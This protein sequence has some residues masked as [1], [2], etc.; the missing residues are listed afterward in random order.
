MSWPKLVSA[1]VVGALVAAGALVLSGVVPL[2]AAQAA[3]V[4]AAQ[5]SCPAPVDPRAINRTTDA[6]AKIDGIQGDSTSAAHRGE[7][8]LTSVRFALLGGASGLCGSG[9][10]STFNPVIVEKRVD[11]ASVPLTRAATLGTHIRTVHI[12]VVSTGANPLTFLT[13]DLTNATVASVRVV[14]RGD[15]LTEEVEFGYTRLQETFTPQKADGSPGA[16]ITF[17]FDQASATA[18]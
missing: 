8:D 9:A 4:P 14:D 7:V 12:A 16:S 1:G 18:C 6:F 5:A 10:R 13:F 17:C 11:S 2:T 3:P 15:S